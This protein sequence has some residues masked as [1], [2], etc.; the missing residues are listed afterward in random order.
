[1]QGR[2]DLSESSKRGK[3]RAILTQ[4]IG[5]TLGLGLTGDGSLRALA[6][7]DDYT[8]IGGLLKQ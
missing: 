3:A 8:V 7:R 4:N 5:V 1:M 6:D 2:S